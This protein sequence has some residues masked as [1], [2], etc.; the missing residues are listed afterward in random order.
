MI[1]ELILDLATRPKEINKT[2]HLVQR[3]VVSHKAKTLQEFK[4]EIEKET[5]IIV[6][7]LVPDHSGSWNNPQT[8]GETIL[9]TDRIGKARMWT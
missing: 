9:S 4:K 6:E 2:G 3:M 8:L 5:F 7:E 1:F